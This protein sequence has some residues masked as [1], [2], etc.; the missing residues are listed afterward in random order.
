M[1]I[2]ID[3]YNRNV[4]EDDLSLLDKILKLYIY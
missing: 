1:Q 3:K 2:L 4:G